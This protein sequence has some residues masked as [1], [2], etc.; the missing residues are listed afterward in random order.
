MLSQL[1]CIFFHGAPDRSCVEIQY[2]LSKHPISPHIITNQY[3]EVLCNNINR[4]NHEPTSSQV[5][6]REINPDQSDE[7]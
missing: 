4:N 6:P 1:A 5:Y 2:K 3:K 7:Y